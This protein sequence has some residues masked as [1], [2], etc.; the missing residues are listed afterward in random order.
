MSD[1]TRTAN[2]HPLLLLVWFMLGLGLRL[3][4]LTLKAPWTDEILTLIY[5]AGQDLRQFPLDQVISLDTLLG[6]LQLDPTVGAKA[7]TQRIFAVSVHPPLYFIVAHYWTALVGF[8]GE[9]FSLAIPRL[10]P[11][12]LG[13]ALIPGAFGLG[14]L[15]LRSHRAAHLAA[16]IMALSP[17][18]IYLSQEARHY[19]LAMVWVMASLACLIAAVQAL[20]RRQPLPMG[21][22]LSWVGVNGLGVATH[23]FMLIT[24][25]AEAFT[26]VGLGLLHHRHHPQA[27]LAPHWRRIYAVAAG[28]A[29]SALVWLPIL[30]QIQSHQITQWI[31]TGD[32][33]SLSALTDPIFQLIAAW[34]TML[35]LLPVESEQWPIV[36][37]SGGIMLGFLIWAIPL[38]W[39]GFRMQW[40]QPEKQL[41][42]QTL[43]GFVGAAIAL[44]LIITY[45]WGT[46]LTRGA[47]YNF[48]YF[49]AVT[50][51]L[52]ASLAPYWPTTPEPE[53][54][55][56][57]GVSSPQPLGTSRRGRGRHAVLLIGVMGLASAVTV[58]TNLGYQKYY[59]PDQLVPLIQATSPTPVLIAATHTTAVQIGDVIAIG[60]EFQQERRQNLGGRSPSP[61]F[62]L[63][64]QDQKR[65]EQNCGATQVLGQAIAQLPRPFEVWL[66]NFRAPAQLEHYHCHL[67]AKP[68]HPVDGYRYQVYQC[69]RSQV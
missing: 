12:L 38:L 1:P 3:S 65:C 68:I 69:P 23:F 46:D 17:F 58:V 36:V 19:T 32:R 35:S 15:A 54:P 25:G 42:L 26:L 62:L 18:G 10:L 52:G 4:G 34:V 14:W 45:G 48:V 33:W 24:L 49:P 43:G 21:L 30:P 41:A 16:V 63:A 59:R 67:S 51:L 27:W 29:V 61:S 8:G 57:N 5:S 60:W 9:R 44:F 22:G 2:C 64:H 37:L 40:H 47:R 20:H 28:T 13:S 50:V 31:Q 53:P 55:H 56:P 11:A 6:W 66:V 39:Q 7:I